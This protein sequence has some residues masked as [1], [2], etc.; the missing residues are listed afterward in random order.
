MSKRPRP[1]LCVTCANAVPKP[2]FDLGCEWSE[3]KA[4]DPVPGWVIKRNGAGVRVVQCPKY[5]QDCSEEELDEVDPTQ[6]DYLELSHA[7]LTGEGRARITREQYLA[8]EPK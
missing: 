2:E 4:R 3:S 5:Q 6:I 7:Y 8:S 1:T